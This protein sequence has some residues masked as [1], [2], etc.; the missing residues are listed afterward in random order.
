[1]SDLSLTAANI[2]WISGGVGMGPSGEAIT[3]GQ[4]VAYDS[5]DGKYYVADAASGTPAR[6][7]ISGIALCSCPAANQRVTFQT[8]GIIDIGATVTQ[9]VLYVVSANAGG[10]C[11]QSDL[12]SGSAV[13]IVGVG[14][15]TAE[16][17]Q[18]AIADTG[19]EVP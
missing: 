5:S 6:E 13:L 16:Q 4:P 3:I 11:P 8:S 14:T 19:L 1:M 12:A 15:S 7:G 9:G 17:I 18:L 2:R 10:I